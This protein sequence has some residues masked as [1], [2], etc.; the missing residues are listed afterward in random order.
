[1]TEVELMHYSL[2]LCRYA[3][4]MILVF[5]ALLEYAVVNSLT[6]LEIDHR[7]RKRAM[8]GPSGKEDSPTH[9]KQN[10]YANMG[11]DMVSVEQAE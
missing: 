5:S 7:R 8:S 1:M 2:F 3:F 4:C 11:T 10:L 9:Y 6:R